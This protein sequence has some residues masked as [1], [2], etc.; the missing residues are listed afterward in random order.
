MSTPPEGTFKDFLGPSS[1][2]SSFF[3]PT[4]PAEVKSLCQALDISKGPGHDDVA[5]A[6]LRYV[7]IELGLPLS[8]LLNACI[9]NGYFPDSWKIARVSPI[10]KQGDPTDLGNYRPISVL[11]VFSKIFERLIQKR[12]LSFLNKQGSILGT[13]YGFRRNHSTL[14]Q[15]WTW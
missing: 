14:W 10:F 7:S 6:V 15:L 5:P 8:N 4:S 12:T 11:P 9:E 2:A 13:Q 3:A 1:Q